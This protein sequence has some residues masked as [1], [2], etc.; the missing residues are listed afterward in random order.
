MKRWGIRG[1]YRS[2]SRWEIRA[3]AG[4][5][6]VDGREKTVW[7]RKFGPCGETYQAAL[8]RRRDLA[9]T[10]KLREAAEQI[11]Q[12]NGQTLANQ[13]TGEQAWEYHHCRQLAEEFDQT[14]SEFCHNAAARLRK[15]GAATL[16]GPLLGDVVEE[17]INH[18]RAQGVSAVYLRRFNFSIRRLAKDYH[19]AINYVS[20]D[21]LFTWLTGLKVG[22]SSWNTYRHDIANLVA[23][24]QKRGYLPSDWNGL[25]KVHL[26]KL[27]KRAPAIYTPERLATILAAASE[28]LLPALVLGA[29]AGIRSAEIARLRWENINWKSGTI[30]LR[31]DITKT[32]VT[33]QVPMPDN[34]KDWLKPWRNNS[35]PVIDVQWL[36]RHK[37]I[38]ARKLGLGRWGRNP[39]RASWISYRLAQTNDIAKVALEAGNSPTKIHQHYLDLV[40]DE[41]AAKWFEI[42]QQTVSQNVL[43]LKFG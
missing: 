12:K 40:S 38:L 42:R 29:F 10:L 36:A 25:D 30:L 26:N 17:F 8:K 7:L 6:I 2:G 13:F 43:P 16:P 24:A 14:L 20:G 3:V 23:F 31:A 19:L 37:G 9:K 18:K 34:L 32:S 4:T 33:R 41:A 15:S 35:G 28:R 5:R 1:I 21:D 39:L 27:K 11:R 22:A